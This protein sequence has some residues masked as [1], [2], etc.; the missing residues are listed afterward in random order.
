MALTPK[1]ELFAREY[2]TDLN[3]TQAAIRAGYSE[4][5]AK[6]QGYRLLTNVHVATFIAEH[7]RPRIEKLALQASDVVEGLRRAAFFDVRKLARWGT[8]EVEET[9][10]TKKGGKTVKTKR[11]VLVPYS[12]LTSSEDIDDE[13]ASAIGGIKMGA[14]GIELK[15]S[16]RIAALGQLGRHFGIFEK[17]RADTNVHV[18]FQIDGA[19]SP[20]YEG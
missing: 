19:T 17:D 4:K 16:D 9:V 10:E 5:T 13:T 12:I 20:A 11:K 18:T 8:R 2:L 7:H 14:H 6:E 3:A 15:M 1:Q